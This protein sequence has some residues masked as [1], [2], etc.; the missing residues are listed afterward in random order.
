MCNI[1]LKQTIKK[2]AIYYGYFGLAI[3]IIMFF[4]TLVNPTIPFHLGVKE[5]Y[6][7]TAGVLSLLFLPLIMVFVGLFHALML[8]YPIIALFRYMKNKRK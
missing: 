6:G 8:W 2:C 3:G 7:F 4:I 1:N 5:F